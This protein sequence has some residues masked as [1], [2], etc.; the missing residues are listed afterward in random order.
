MFGEVLDADSLQAELDQ[1]VAD[2][3]MANEGAIPDAG[4]A[5]IPANQ[6]PAQAQLEQEEEEEQPRQMVAA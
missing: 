3:I 5:H 4:T 2:D 1:L 6:V